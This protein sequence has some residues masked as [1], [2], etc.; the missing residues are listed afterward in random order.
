MEKQLVGKPAKDPIFRQRDHVCLLVRERATS[1]TRKV[2]KVC[3]ESQCVQIGRMT[4]CARKC[5]KDDVGVLILP[6]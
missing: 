1:D 4:C 6:K 2:E 3:Q 5:R